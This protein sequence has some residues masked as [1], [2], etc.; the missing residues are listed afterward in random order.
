M[1]VALEAGRTQ[2]GVSE[3]LK[4]FEHT[5]RSLTAFK[6]L[7]IVASREM[8]KMLLETGGKWFFVM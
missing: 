6:G 1:G 3:S 5:I 7:P 4:F 2:Q 8:R